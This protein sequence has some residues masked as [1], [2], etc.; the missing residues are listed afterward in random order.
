MAASD[1]A[2]KSVAYI[3]GRV[4][5]IAGLL[6]AGIGVRFAAASNDATFLPR[7]RLASTAMELREAREENGCHS[8]RARGSHPPRRGDGTPQVSRACL[9]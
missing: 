3:T 5:L 9:A 4:P 6:R 2:E 7:A 8:S 1:A